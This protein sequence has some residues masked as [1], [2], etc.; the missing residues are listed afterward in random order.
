VPYESIHLFQD[1]LKRIV[2]SNKTYYDHIS[3]YGKS[4]SRDFIS[5]P[6]YEEPMFADFTLDK[7][8]LNKTIAEHMYRSGYFESG[9]AFTQE[10]HVE[11]NPGDHHHGDDQLTNEFKERFRL[12]NRIVS[13]FRE[14]R[15]VK[16]AL[17]WAKAHGP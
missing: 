7:P 9:E 15:D 8:V 10:A 2:N 13:E 3:K 11:V 1:V 16:S 14:G 5:K 4:V 6:E 17:E 12:L